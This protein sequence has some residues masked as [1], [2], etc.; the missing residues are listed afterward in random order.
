MSNLLFDLD[1]T[2]IDSGQGILAA[3]EET[4]RRTG[5]PVPDLETLTS[6]I[7]PP[8]VVTFQQF[9]DQTEEVDRAVKLFRAYYDNKGVYQ[10]KPYDGIKET[11]EQLAKSHHLFVTTSKNQPM[12][13][14]MLEHFGLDSSLTA[15]Y[16]ATPD[17]H[18]KADLIEAC[19]SDHQLD[20]EETFIIGDTKFDMIG[21][22]DTGIKTIFA[23]WGFGQESDLHECQPDNILAKPCQLLDIFSN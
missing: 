2:L 23:D 10:A 22:R 3:F 15:I 16:G 17:R 7:G 20:K 1:G 9:F 4:F 5:I 6:F 21:G 19:L 11:L 14:L 8:L 18:H 13:H 12:A